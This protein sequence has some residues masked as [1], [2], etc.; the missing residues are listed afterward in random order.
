METIGQ[1]RYGTIIYQS[2]DLVTFLTKADCEEHFKSAE[3]L[4]WRKIK[5]KQI[6][7][8][9]RKAKFKSKTNFLKNIWETFK[10]HYERILK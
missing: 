6:E 5:I 1:Y 2:P 7:S 9:R 10:K 8:E 3:Y 4:K